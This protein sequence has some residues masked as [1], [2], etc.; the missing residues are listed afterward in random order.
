M[1]NYI[2]PLSKST[3]PDKMNTSF[4]PRIDRNKW[5]FHD[6]IDLPALIGTKV[7]AM[8][9]GTVHRA[10]P[11][12]TDGFSSCHIILEV[13]D[14]DDELYLVYVHLHSI[15]EGI[16]VGENVKQGELIGTVGEESATYPH[17]HIEFRKGGSSQEHSVHPLRYLPY[18][19][20]PN[21]TAP[22]SDRFN[23]LDD[24]L[25]AARLL[26]GAKSKLEGDLQRVEVDINSGAAL[27][28]TRIVDFNDKDTINEGNGDEFLFKNGIGVEGYQ[29]SD[30][31][32]DGRTDLK[33]GIL[34]RS[35]PSDCD[36]LVARVFDVKGNIATSM[37]ISVPKQ[38]A[39]DEIVD[40]EDGEM[41]PAGWDKVESDSGTGTTV[42]NKQISEPT[43]GRVMLSIDA[44]TEEQNRQKAGIEYALPAGRFE[45]LAK[46]SFNPTKLSLAP[47]KTIDLLHFRD[48]GG[49]NLS[50]AA[51]IFKDVNR[52]RA[53]LIVKQPDGTLSP[54]TSPDKTAV[55]EKNTWREWELRVLRIG[56]RETTVI[57]SLDKEEKRR[58]NWDST[59]HEPLRLRAGIGHSSVGATATVQT[60]DLRL[61]EMSHYD[62][63]KYTGK[64]V[65]R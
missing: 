60:D 51:R 18:N 48:S 5:D 44:S 62:V 23:R 53:G 33:Y 42:T 15:A 32:K 13:D 59:I 26:F 45:W 50:V 29:K 65:D 56:T 58:V 49:A 43:K 2:W 4:G 19:D 47:G 39:T 12:G 40:F 8:H 61:T 14:Q 6:G 27:L 28:E 30:M 64:Q 46:G 17:L 21:F 54:S 25:M 16:T 3:R 24:G 37:P 55:I 52:L 11:G 57:L 1:A 7:Y 63:K 22:V 31:V 36:T 41:P 10:G 9:D 38:I 35:L 34:V 20:T